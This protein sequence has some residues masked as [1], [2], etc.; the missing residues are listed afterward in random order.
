MK[1]RFEV[2]LP[3][4]GDMTN[5]VNKIAHVL[6]NG[7]RVR[8]GKRGQIKGFTIPLNPD[9]TPATQLGYL[10]M[11]VEAPVTDY[12]KDLIRAHK[13][14]TILIGWPKMERP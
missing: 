12:F 7:G 2:K 6:N 8:W 11:L 10:N 13:R 4:P 14:A 9:K 5:E 1:Y 3:K